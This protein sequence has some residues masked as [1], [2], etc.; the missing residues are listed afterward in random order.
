[1]SSSTYYPPPFDPAQVVAAAIMSPEKSSASDIID[2]WRR[3]A[4]QSGTCLRDIFETYKVPFDCVIAWLEDLR[5]NCPNRVT[6]RKLAELR[7]KIASRTNFLSDNGDPDTIA[8]FEAVRRMWPE[9]LKQAKT[10]WDASRG[11]DD[12]GDGGG[13]AG[14][15]GSSVPPRP[16]H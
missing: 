15:G 8:E 12:D 6:Q 5:P 3:L 16:G 10:W 14:G 2:R 11:S 1:M 7:G 9:V 13:G 4:L